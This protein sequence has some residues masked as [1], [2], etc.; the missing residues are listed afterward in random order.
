MI[1]LSGIFILIAIVV[2]KVYHEIHDT[3]TPE[4]VNDLQNKLNRMALDRANERNK[5]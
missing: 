3:P 1:A 5:P 4:E 2:I